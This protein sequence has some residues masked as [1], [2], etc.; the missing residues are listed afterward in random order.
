V[1][2]MKKRKRI[3]AWKR[4]VILLYAIACNTWLNRPGILKQKELQNELLPRGQKHG[5]GW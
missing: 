4:I 2:K 1:R 3:C 5:L